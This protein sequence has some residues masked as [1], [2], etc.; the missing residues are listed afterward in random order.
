MN[1][2]TYEINETNAAGETEKFDEEACALIEKLGLTGQ[3]QLMTKNPAGDRSVVPYNKMTDEEEAV[4]SVLFDERSSAESYAAGPI[5]IRVLQV[6]AFAR[7]MFERLEI[8]GPRRGGRKDDP[9]LIGIRKTDQ[10]TNSRY[11]LARWGDALKPFNE[12]RK[13]AAEKSRETVKSALLKVRHEVELDIATLEASPDG[14]VTE[15]ATNAPY[16]HSNRPTR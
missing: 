4:Y 13:L 8:W 7:E 10:W 3:T 16:Y 9:V 11:L 5:P 12:L 6:I 15:W 14:P 2:E 1:V